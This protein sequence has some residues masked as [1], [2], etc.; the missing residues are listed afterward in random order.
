MKPNRV[1]SCKFYVIVLAFFEVRMV[2]VFLSPYPSLDWKSEFLKDQ[3][4]IW[5][6]C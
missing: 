2:G 5:M 4:E 3:L 6:F 1:V